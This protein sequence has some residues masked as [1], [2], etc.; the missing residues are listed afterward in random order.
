QR[1]IDGDRLA[2]PAAVVAGVV[3]RNR[4]QRVRP[5]AGD[6][7]R[8]TGRTARLRPA[9]DLVLDDVNPR[10]RVGTAERDRVVVLDRRAGRGRRVRRRDVVDPDGLVAIAGLVAGDVL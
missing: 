5:V 2:L 4:L 1:Q 10:V 3:D 9:V 8:R 7:H 6:L